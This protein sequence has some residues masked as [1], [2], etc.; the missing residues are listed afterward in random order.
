MG[1][2]H[3]SAKDQKETSLFLA[4]S[5]SHLLPLLHLHL[6]PSEVPH[7]HSETGVYCLGFVP[8]GVCISGSAI[9]ESGVGTSISASSVSHPIAVCR[10]LADEK[11]TVLKR[12]SRNVDKTSNLLLSISWNLRFRDSSIVD[13]NVWTPWSS[14]WFSRDRCSNWYWGYHH[15]CWFRSRWSLTS[16][17]FKAL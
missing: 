7:I 17:F 10:V 11:K 8:S 6:F 3:V 12:G 13:V 16:E 1:R 4:A 14:V 15:R 2:N 5:P 9:K